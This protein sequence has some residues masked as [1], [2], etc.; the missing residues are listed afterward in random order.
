MTTLNI[1]GFDAL[2]NRSPAPRRFSPLADQVIGLRHD[3][4]AALAD[5]SMRSADVRFRA[6]SGPPGMTA[7]D[8]F[9][10]LVL[11]G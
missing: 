3:F 2:S 5:V 9:E 11:G 8:P 1:G 4:A 10:T 6:N 7:F